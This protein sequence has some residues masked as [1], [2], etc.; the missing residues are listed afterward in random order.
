VEYLNGTKSVASIYDGHEVIAQG[1]FGGGTTTVVW[2]HLKPFTN[3][4]VN[5]N[6]SA[7]VN[8]RVAPDPVEGPDVGDADP[9]YSSGSPDELGGRSNLNG[10]MPGLEASLNDHAVCTDWKLGELD[11]GLANVALE[12]GGADLRDIPGSIDGWLVWMQRNKIPGHVETDDTYSH[13]DVL[14][15]GYVVDPQFNRGLESPDNKQKTCAD[16]LKQAGKTLGGLQRAL[17]DLPTIQQ[18]VADPEFAKLLAA[19]GIQ[20]SDF[21]NVKQNNGGPGRGVFQIEPKAYGISEQQAM[22]LPDAVDA[23]ST[24]LGEQ[25]GDV[26][27][28]LDNSGYN[29]GDSTVQYWALASLARIHNRWT[30]GVLKKSKKAWKIGSLLRSGLN[31][32]NVND[33]DNPGQRIDGSVASTANGTYVRNVMDIFFS[34][35]GG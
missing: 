16:A 25:W 23:L 35:F 13:G 21:Q 7:V 6:S 10:I 20:E 1:I 19:I 28:A 15:E 24:T 34:C 5:T 4:G 29:V 17:N 26:I 31:S 22:N 8:N 11:C 18:I 30:S 14:W 32:G 27:T 3:D 12:M 9:W 33:L 2:Q